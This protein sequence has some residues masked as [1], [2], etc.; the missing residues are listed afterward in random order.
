MSQEDLKTDISKTA[1][2]LCNDRISSKS[3]VALPEILA[4]IRNQLEWL[5][6]YFEGKNNDRDKLKTLVFG[7]YAAQEVDDRDK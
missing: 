3:A 2:R 5:V 7:H 6:L 1:L 4:S